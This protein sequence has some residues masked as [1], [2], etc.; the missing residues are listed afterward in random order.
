MVVFIVLFGTVGGMGLI[1]A[2]IADPG[3]IP[4]AVLWMSGPVVFLR[5]QLRPWFQHRR[6]RYALTDQRLVLSWQLKQDLAEVSYLLT[7]LAPPL[8]QRLNK[9]GTGS[10]VLGRLD[11]PGEVVALTDIPEAAVVEDLIRQAQADRLAS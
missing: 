10:I 8:L 3:M 5:H 11:A 2:A 6:L 1:P 7:S 4:F 9:D